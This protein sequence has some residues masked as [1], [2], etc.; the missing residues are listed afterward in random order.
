MA[1]TLQRWKGIGRWLERVTAVPGTLG[2]LKVWAR[3][4][5][6]AWAWLLVALPG[7]AFWLR[8]WLAD[9]I[10]EVLVVGASFVVSAYGISLLRA[11][12]RRVEPEVKRLQALTR[13]IR[14]ARDTFDSRESGSGLRFISLVVELSVHLE[15]LGIPCPPEPETVNDL[16]PWLRF[17]E[18][19][20]PLAELGSLEQARSLV[21]S[22][23]AG[24]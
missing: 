17:V 9:R 2:D 5:S 12:A 15:A 3:W 21:N 7:P 4:L 16:E 8:G 10:L 1:N 18:K 14:E 24:P 11:Q 6:K 23:S 22:L 13:R 19:L 20:L